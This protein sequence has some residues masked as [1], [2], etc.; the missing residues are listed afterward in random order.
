M[1]MHE[2]PQMGKRSTPKRQH[3]G[4]R[5]WAGLCREDQRRSDGQAIATGVAGLSI[6]DRNAGGP[7]L[8]DTVASLE[9]LKAARAAID[10]SGEDVVLVARTEGLLFNPATLK[11]AVDK[12]ATFRRKI[13]VFGSTV[14]GLGPSKDRR[15]AGGL[16]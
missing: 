12:L 9:R 8:Y 5:R 10:R 4:L 1:D 13:D 3:C 16:F 6:E 14:N 11:P 15:G 7:G 2:S